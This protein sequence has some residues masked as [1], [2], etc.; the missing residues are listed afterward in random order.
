MHR[1]NSHWIIKALALTTLCAWPALAQQLPPAAPSALPTLP[2]LPAPAAATAPVAPAA[3]NGLPGLPPLPQ[4]AA[5]AAT[6]PAVA[7]P[8]PPTIPGVNVPAVGLPAVAL[9]Q[10]PA[11][12]PGALP[13][14]GVVEAGLPS[15]PQ[16]SKE[17]INKDIAPL[18]AGVKAP[19]E[20][21]YSYGNS[22]LSVLFLP[23]QIEKMKEATRAFE[24]TNANG[25]VFATPAQP[26]PVA[27]PAIVEPKEYPVFYLSSVAYDT[28]ADWSLWLSGHKIT[29]RKNE[30]D[31]KV[32]NVTREGATFVWTPTYNSAISKRRTSGQFA[33][34]DVVKNK[35]AV[36]QSLSQ[37]EDTGA[38]TFTLRQNQTFAVAY[39]SIF[40]GYMDTTPVPALTASAT[41]LVDANIGQP[42]PGAQPPV[43]IT[44]PAP[45]INTALGTM[46]SLPSDANNPQ[47]NL[48][49][50]P[51]STVPVGA[52]PSGMPAAAPPALG[53]PLMNA[54]SR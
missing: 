30:T 2:V 50:P 42:P 39:F 46:S 13:N 27:A 40:E 24:N 37:N 7:A 19:E 4:A 53:A 15:M 34:T 49:N 51:M 26:T 32:I 25:P 33:T 28:P 8:V 6:A 17:Q 38:V 21:Q 44:N 41:P 22:A 23:L 29:S 3:S 52:P 20:K 10:T 36:N 43:G 1:M 11:A 16:Q 48:N 5:P 14:A 18:L 45:Q 9:P 12:V 54:P 31:V 35:L 47:R